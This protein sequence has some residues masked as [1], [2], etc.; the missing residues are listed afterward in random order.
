VALRR[1]ERTRTGRALK[2]VRDSPS[3]A[4]SAGI[5][6]QSYRSLAFGISSLCAGLAGVLL[7]LVYQT[8]VP[9]GFGL[10]LSILYLVMVV[11]GGP[12]SAVGSIVAALVVTGLPLVLSHYSADLPFVS[13]P[14]DSGGVD[15]GTASQYVFGLAMVV[16]LLGRGRRPR[17]VLAA[18]RQAR[19]LRSDP[20]APRA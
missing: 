6:V 19:R 14:G 5:H 15:A 8:I 11:V 2:I 4:A 17:L 9:D 18:R 3:A 12:R 1:L 16:V 20:A 7:A 10:S 13:Q